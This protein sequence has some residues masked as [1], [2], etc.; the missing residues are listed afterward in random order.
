LSSCN[1]LNL[2]RCQ[3]CWNHTCSWS[4]KPQCQDFLWWN[5]DTFPGGFSTTRVAP[6]PCHTLCR[7]I[8]SPDGLLCGAPTTPEFRERVCYNNCI[9]TQP[10]PGELQK[11]AW[12][13]YQDSQMSHSRILDNSISVSR[14]PIWGQ[15]N[16]HFMCSFNSQRSQ[17]HTKMLTTWLNFYAF[18]ICGCK[19]CS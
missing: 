9:L 2:N 14:E 6:Y 13:A 11:D 18:G 10:Q 7:C 3:T 5:G 17:K 1:F 19:R 4:E 15:F 12:P 8:S 16:Q